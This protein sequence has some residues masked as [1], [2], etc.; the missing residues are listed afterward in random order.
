MA[1]IIPKGEFLHEFMTVTG[2]HLERELPAEASEETM[3]L[4]AMNIIKNQCESALEA[5]RRPQ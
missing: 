3:I 2:R 5:L 1:V 4:A